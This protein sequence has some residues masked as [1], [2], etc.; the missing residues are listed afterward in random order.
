MSTGDI[1]LGTASWTDKTLLES[2]WY[3]SDI[4]T[5]DARLRYYAEQFPLVEVDSTYYTPPNERNSEF[6]FIS[7][8]SR[9]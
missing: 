2:G 6:A 9:C 3:P 1:L 7:R 4:K 5:P 8:L